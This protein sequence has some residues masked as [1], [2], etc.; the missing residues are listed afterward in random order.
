[1]V[2]DEWKIVHKYLNIVLKDLGAQV[3]SHPL[4]SSNLDELGHK[5]SRVHGARELIQA[6]ST[7]ERNLMKEK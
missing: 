4:D 1:M 2:Q 7:L 5:L 3:L 6:L